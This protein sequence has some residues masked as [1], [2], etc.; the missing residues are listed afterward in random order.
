MK[1]LTK[2]FMNGFSTLRK[3]SITCGKIEVIEQDSFSNMQQLTS[4]NLNRNRIRFI[5]KNTFSNLNNLESLS[6]YGNY[7]LRNVDPKFV[8]LINTAKFFI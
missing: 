8:G 6:L 2:G 1:R 3:L 7:K 5:Y 4:L